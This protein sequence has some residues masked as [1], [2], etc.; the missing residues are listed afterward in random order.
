VYSEHIPTAKKTAHL[1]G[2][3]LLTCL[4]GTTPG[5]H[6]L[7]LGAQ[8]TGF[9]HE[10]SGGSALTTYMGGF[11]SADAESDYNFITSFT[12]MTLRAV[13]FWFNFSL[14]CCAFLRAWIGR[15]LDTHVGACLTPPP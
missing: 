7:G 8:D 2:G 13:A 15:N 14:Q 5:F 3:D 10:P 1:G 11:Y 12:G 9:S 6:D 4:G